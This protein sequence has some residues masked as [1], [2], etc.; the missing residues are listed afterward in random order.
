MPWIALLESEVYRA[1]T[2]AMC[3]GHQAPMCIVNVDKF[4]HDTFHYND[5]PYHPDGRFRQL[6]RNGLAGVVKEVETVISSLHAVAFRTT[7]RVVEGQ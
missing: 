1:P 5:V 6:V 2:V 4:I 3:C 7:A